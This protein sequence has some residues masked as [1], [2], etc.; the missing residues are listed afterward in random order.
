[1]TGVWADGCRAG[2]CF[3]NHCMS[4]GVNIAALLLLATMEVL[5]VVQCCVG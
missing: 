1:M 4:F 2:S 5:L 3:V